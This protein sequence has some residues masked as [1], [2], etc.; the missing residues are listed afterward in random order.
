VLTRRWL[1]WDRMAL[2]ATVALPLFLVVHAGL[3]VGMATTEPPLFEHVALHAVLFA[4]GVVFWLPVFGRRRRL[5]DP[6]RVLY[7][8]LAL[9]SLDLAGVYLVLRGMSQDGVSMIVGM[10]PAGALA[11]AVAWE[12]MAREEREAV[13]CARAAET[14]GG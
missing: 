12:W 1:R 7:L 3:T 11:V 6:G 13:M 4:A 5:S 2:P 10:L 9:P 8:F 14:V